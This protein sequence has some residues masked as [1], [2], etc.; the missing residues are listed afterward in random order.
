MTLTGE[1]NERELLN[2]ALEQTESFKTIKQ[3]LSAAPALGIPDVTQPFNLFVD[4]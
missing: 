1:D 4:K 2:W 3:V